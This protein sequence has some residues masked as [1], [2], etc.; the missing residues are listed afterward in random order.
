[1]RDEQAKVLHAIQPFC[2]EEVLSTHRARPI[3]RGRNR[4]RSAR[5]AIAR[6]VKR[7]TRLSHR[8]LRGDENQSSTTGVGPTFPFMFAPASACHR[9]HSHRH[10][11][12]PRAVCALP[13]HRSRQADAEPVGAPYPARRRHLS[14]VSAAKTPGPVMRLGTVDMDFEYA[15][16]F[17]RAAVHRIRTAVCTTA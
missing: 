13:R 6:G 1:M 9:G 10:S 4:R 8:N 17:G 14:A 11:I 15:D 7:R 2:S 3:R 16:Y 5:P 12:S